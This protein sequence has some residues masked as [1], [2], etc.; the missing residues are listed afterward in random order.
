M[1]VSTWKPGAIV[2]SLDSGTTPYVVGQ[3]RVTATHRLRLQV[4]LASGLLEWE[5]DVSPSLRAWCQTLPT[6]WPSLAGSSA[7][8]FP[9]QLRREDANT[10]RLRIPGSGGNRPWGVV[11]LLSHPSQVNI[12]KAIAAALNNNT[13]EDAS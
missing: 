13:V 7:K 2:P 9:L 8:Y 3:A 6:P 12:V 4:P 11:V 5:A 1:S 10:L